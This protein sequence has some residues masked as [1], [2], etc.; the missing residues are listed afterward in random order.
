MKTIKC[1]CGKRVRVNPNGRIKPHLDADRSCL[2]GGQ[3]ATFITVHRASIV[4]AMAP[5][6]EL[7]EKYKKRRGRK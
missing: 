6:V 7:G 3:T 2:W 5:N 1:L 4:E